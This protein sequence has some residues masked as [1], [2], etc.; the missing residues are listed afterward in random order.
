MNIIFG[1]FSSIYFLIIFSFFL[2]LLRS[3][4]KRNTI[5]NKIS[6]IVAARNEEKNLPA[7]LEILLDQTYPSEL[8][9]V[10]IA[11]DRSEDGTSQ[12]VQ[13]FQKNHSNLKLVKI[14]QENPDLVG[15]KGALTAAIKVSQNGILAFTDADCLP[16]KYWLEEIN[17]HFTEKT[18]FLA[19][20]SFIKLKNKVFELLK[21]LERAA[22]FAVIG[23]GFGWNWGLTCGASNIA[24]RRKTYDAVNGFDGIGHIRSGDDDLMLQKMSGKIR[25]MRFL[26]SQRSFITTSGARTTNDQINLETRRASKWKYYPVSIKLLTL[27]VFAYYVVFLIAF[28]A[29][30]SQSI[31]WTSFSILLILKLLPEFLLLLTFL[32]KIKK[33]NLMSIFPIAELIYIPYFIFFGLKGTFGRYRWKE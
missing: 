16:T 17:S 31:S 13:Q 20:Y 1:S 22:L 15:K 10:V 8:Y 27:F 25:Q 19:G 5:Q 23:G 24:Y 18:D 12:I 26:F 11:D 29:V 28:T 7:L 9:E 2:G 33:L 21:N 3:N 30:L 6:V 4:G 14:K 32:L